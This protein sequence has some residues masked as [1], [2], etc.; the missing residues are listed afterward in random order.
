MHSYYELPE[1]TY[2]NQEINAAIDDRGVYVIDQI[3]S[4]IS[5]EEQNQVPENRK[6]GHKPSLQGVYDDLYD[7]N[8]SPQASVDSPHQSIWN[9]YVCLKP[10]KSIIIS[11][12]GGFL[13]GAVVV[14]IIF[15]L[16]E[17]TSMVSSSWR[18]TDTVTSKIGDEPTTKQTMQNMKTTRPITTMITIL[19]HTTTEATQQKE[20][21]CDE[22][23][24][25]QENDILSNGWESNSTIFNS[26]YEVFC[27]T[28][29]TWYGWNPGTQ[30]GA[31]YF[32]FQEIGTAYFS[33]ENCHPFGSVEVYLNEKII[34][35]ASSSQMKNVTFDYLVGD[36]LTITEIFAIWKLHFLKLC[37]N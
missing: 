26:V 33:F 1:V 10:K 17:H 2:E 20:T 18:T 12:I 21:V 29:H 23:D 11:T 30:V 19:S 3:R 24:F 5:S 25:R 27:D 28:E 34:S 16:Q 14:L 6:A 7:Y 9:K 36:K 8:I 13:I 22:I 15:I 35:E 32:I 31:I 4:K 37:Y